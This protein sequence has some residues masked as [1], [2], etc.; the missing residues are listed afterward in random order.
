MR[1][2]GRSAN[3]AC[4]ATAEEK[5][6]A[7]VKPRRVSRHEAIACGDPGSADKT[8]AGTG[9]LDGREGPLGGPATAGGGPETKASEASTEPPA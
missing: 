3:E 6:A 1:E 7:L 9:G 2:D 5:P 4:E 8:E